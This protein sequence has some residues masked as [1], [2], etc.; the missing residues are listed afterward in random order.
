MTVVPLYPNRFKTAAQ[1]YTLGRPTYP[2]ALIEQVARFVG[3]DRTQTVLDLGTGPGFLAIDF[4]PWAKSVTAIDPEPEMLRAAKENA[5]QAG[6]GIAFVQASSNDLD[7]SYGRFR[8]VTIGRAFHW[9]DRAETLRRLDRL[10]EPEGAI[11]LF[12]EHY[13]DVPANRWHAEFQGLVDKYSTDDPAR[14]LV[15][16]APKHET[17][18]LDSA[19]RQLGRIS[20]LEPRA[21]PVDR[22]VD[23][24]LSFATTWH[25]RPGSRTDDLAIEIREAMAKYAVDG[26]VHEVIEGEA[27]I[28]RR[29]SRVPHN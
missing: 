26:V 17:V 15:R 10:I 7:D 1:Y 3:L 16:Q 14:A 5:I 23:R 12:G 20:A 29:P 6:V 4:A 11:A 8:L 18:L 19:F 25:G 27:L 24:A 2:A 22:F 9:M 21:T 28:A 13:P